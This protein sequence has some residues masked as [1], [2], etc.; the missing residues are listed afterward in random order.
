MFRDRGYGVL[1]AMDRRDAGDFSVEHQWL[2]EAFA[3][4]AATAVATAKSATPI[5][6]ASGLP[7][8]KL[9][10]RDG[11]ASY[12]RDVA[13]TRKSA[14][15]VLRARRADTQEAMSEAIDQALQ[16]LDFDIAALAGLITELRPAALDQLGLEPALLAL[17]DRVRAKGSRSTARSS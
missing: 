13:G 7:R 5:A 15:G 12:T 2:L 14:A 8:P 17:A 6:C 10:A 11:L 3:A 9:S 16:Q 1:V 4:S